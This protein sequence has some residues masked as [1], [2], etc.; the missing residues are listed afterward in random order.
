[1]LPGQ[2]LSAWKLLCLKSSSVMESQL[3]LR[4]LCF[5]PLSDSENRDRPPVRI[6]SPW[7]CQLAFQGGTGQLTACLAVSRFHHSAGSWALYGAGQ[8]CADVPLESK[9]SVSVPG[10][11]NK[12]RTG[13]RQHRPPYRTRKAARRAT[14]VPEA[15]LFRPRKEPEKQAD[16]RTQEGP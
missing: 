6:S 12:A 13:H 9:A 16:T 14:P 1:M 8:E 3:V 11:R 2:G 10:L 4:A 7:L 5:C 15:C